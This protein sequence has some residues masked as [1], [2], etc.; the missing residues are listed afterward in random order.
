MSETEGLN[1]GV[2]STA[3]GGPYF[4]ELLGGMATEL[5]ATGGRLI[6][7]PDRRRRNRRTGLSRAAAVPHRV[8][9]D[10][11]AGFI[12]LLNGVNLDYLLA[13]RNTGRPVVVISD[14]PHGFSC[15]IIL[16]DN[17]TGTAPRLS[18]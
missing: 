5:V 3:F 11:I 10:H 18:T 8:A 13:A 16:P 17:F 7:D 2:L 12:V 15:P 9:W 4:G 6:A 1:V 14:D